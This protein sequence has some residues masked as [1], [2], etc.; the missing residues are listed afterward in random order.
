V[1]KEA[2]RGWR[3]AAAIGVFVAFSLLSTQVFGEYGYLK[4]R[5]QK[6]VLSQIEEQV[7]VQREEKQQREER[8]RKLQKDPEA[9]EKIAREEMKL[10]RPGEV[11]YTDPAH[12]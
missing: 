2:L 11:I 7:R 8:V 4:L 1:L 12:K 3:L 5:E 6:R 9:I 10:V